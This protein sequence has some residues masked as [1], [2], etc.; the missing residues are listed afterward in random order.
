MKNVFLLL[1]IFA[2]HH[3]H[4]SLLIPLTS[5]IKVIRRKRHYAL[6]VEHRV[7]HSHSCSCW[8]RASPPPLTCTSLC[9]CVDRKMDPQKK[10]TCIIRF[11]Y[12]FCILTFV[13]PKEIV[14][15]FVHQKV[16]VVFLRI[17]LVV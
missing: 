12:S 15:G 9:T 11:N 14:L 6:G 10:D 7:D 3:N 13:W 1:L 4:T 17:H 16:H 2:A 8:G 5:V